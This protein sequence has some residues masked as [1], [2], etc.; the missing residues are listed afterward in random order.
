[1]NFKQQRVIIDK[2]LMFLC[3]EMKHSDCTSCK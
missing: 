2:F 3:R 1:V